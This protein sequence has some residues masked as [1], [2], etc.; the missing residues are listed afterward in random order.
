MKALQQ[1]YRRVEVETAEMMGELII[2]HGVPTNGYQAAALADELFLPIMESRNRMWMREAEALA[3]EHPGIEIGD[4]RPYNKQA[5][6]KLVMNCAGLTKDMQNTVLLEYYDPATQKMMKARVSP[7]LAAD[8]PEVIEAFEN[9]VRAATARHIKQASRDL[10]ADT[11]FKNGM[12]WARQLTGKE[13]C[14]MCAMLASRGA[15]YAKDTVLKKR[16]GSRYHDHCDCTATL[17]K[18][19]RYDG[20]DEAR[21]LYGLWIQA[22]GDMAQFNKL[23]RE[24]NSFVGISA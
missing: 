11:A 16:D 3:R 19:G 22:N 15:V 23:Y 18:G 24:V 17:V 2:K 4:I 21:D 8:T 14:A 10:V 7:Y 12:G 13:N 20:D 1:A 6:K 5:T 9:R